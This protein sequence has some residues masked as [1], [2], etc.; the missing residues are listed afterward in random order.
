MKYR[1]N[2]VY[3]VAGGMDV[4]LLDDFTMLFGERG[5][6]KAALDARD[7]EAP[8]L[9]SNSDIG[10]MMASVDSRLGV[11]RSGPAGNPEHDA[12]GAGR[13]RPAGGF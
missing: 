13:C 9:N 7:G 8:S 4:A 5:A 6:V 3:P 1:L 11:E 10:S 12:L 2:V